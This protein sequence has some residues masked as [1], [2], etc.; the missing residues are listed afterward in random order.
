[1]EET[2][3]K[4]TLHPNAKKFSKENQ[5]TPEQKSRGWQELR[6]ERHLTQIIVKAMIGKDGK[7]T[8]ALEAYYASLVTNARL[9]NAKAIETINKCLEDD[10]I[11]VA[12]TDGQGN[13]IQPLNDSQVD[14]IIHAIKTS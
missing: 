4:R 11:K 6:K 5:P 7:P 3:K 10:I 12:Q 9:G 14:K 13:D 2:K 1:M 8:E